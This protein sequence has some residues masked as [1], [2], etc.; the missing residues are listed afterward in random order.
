MSL[1]GHRRIWGRIVRRGFTLVE[2][3]VVI[4]IIGILV[5]LL[6][7][8]V[9]AARE[10]ARKAQCTNN[11]KQ[12]GVGMHNYHAQMGTFPAGTFVWVNN[13]CTPTAADNVTGEGYYIG[14]GWSAFL[15]PYIEEGAT[16]DR[17]NFVATSRPSN[18]PKISPYTGKPLFMDN[19]GSGGQGYARGLSFD[20]SATF[21]PTYLCPADPQGR[22]LVDCDPVGPCGD[23]V[24]NG[25]HEFEDCARSNMAG[26]SGDGAVT[27]F[28]GF[29]P[30]D[31]GNGVFYNHSRIRSKDITDGLSKTMF[32]AE[33]VGNPP[34]S[35]SGYFWISMAQVSAANGINA[36][37]SRQRLNT[38]EPDGSRQN[39][40]DGGYCPWGGGGGGGFA[41]YHPG[42]CN[43]LMGDGAVRFFSQNIDFP[44]LRA[45]S[46]RNGDEFIDDGTK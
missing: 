15:L 1:S 10:A 33:V 25:V 7:P 46:T 4:A 44:L 22:E 42:G 20:A 3:L 30:T 29:T 28:D 43:I 11:F 38:Y 26:V 23:G 18:T 35:F 19:G 36:A 41:S 45:Y 12:V 39:C 32:V 37:I 2:L 27:C 14:W 5:A 40:N 16:Y 34:K 21:I 9:Q 6:L 13:E 24:K 31:R 8:A 17:I